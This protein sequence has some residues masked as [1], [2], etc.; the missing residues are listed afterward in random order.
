EERLAR[1]KEEEANIAF[2]ES[3]DNTQAIMDADYELVVRLQEEERRELTI[4]EKSMLFVEL[5]DKR[6]KYFARLKAEKI[7]SKPPTKTQKRNQMCTYL[8]NIENYKYSQLKNNSFE[9][10]QMLFNNTMK[11]IESFV[12]MDTELVKGSEKAAE[13]SSK[14]AGAAPLSSKSPTIVDYKIYKEGRKSFFKIIKA[15]VEVK[16]AQVVDLFIYTSNHGTQHWQAI[17]RLLKYLKKTMDYRLVYSGYPS[18]LEGYTYASWISNTEDNSSTSGWVF[19]LSGAAGNEAEWLK[20][21]LLEI[22]MWVKPMEPIFIRCDSAT[23]LAKAYIQMYNGKS[24]HLGVRHSMTREL[25]TNGMVSIEFVRNCTKLERIVGNLVELYGSVHT[26]KFKNMP[27][28]QSMEGDIEDDASSATS[29]KERSLV[30]QCFE[31]IEGET[32]SDRQESCNN[33]GKVFSAKP[34]QDMYREK[35]AIAIIQHNYSFSYVEHDATRQLHKFLHRDTNPISRNTAKL[36][37]LAIYKR[38]KANLKLK[39]E[40]VS[41]KI[42]FTSDLWSSITSDGYMALTAHYVD[43]DCVLRKKVLNFRVV[44]P[45][46]T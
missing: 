21:L 14:R 23:T 33:C 45:P 43:E 24:R 12:L 38:E 42:C 8:K 20:N 22:P 34:D 11:W 19:L 28:Q 29:T 15:D 35:M 4:E 32:H 17:Q 31:K 46:Y 16:T 2:I 41:S 26:W 10:I 37:V 7:R 3:W 30:W 40:K 13:G 1:Q 25:I 27:R 39:L 6:K 44:P 5:M 9:E 36:D 18:V